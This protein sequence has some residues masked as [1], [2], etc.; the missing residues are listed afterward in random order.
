MPTKA[1]SRKN[2][3]SERE[4]QI[5]FFSN[6]RIEA[7]VELTHNTDGVYR[8]TLFEFKLTIPDINKVLFQSLKYL[9]HRR[10]KGDPVPTQILL[11]ALNEENAYL[12]NSED[13]LSYIEQT[14][15]G[16]ASKNNADFSTHIQPQKIDY[17]Q[18][19]GLRRITEI[20]EVEKYTKIHIDLFDVVGWSGRFYRENPTASKIKLFKELR[21]PKYFAAYIYP[22]TGDEK[23][24]KYIMDLLNDKQHKKELGA[25]YTPPAYCL[26]A[27]ELVRKAIRQI[28]A[29]H[30]YIILDRCA[31]TGNLE[32]FLTD[33]P[34]DDITI[35]ELSRYIDDTQKKKYLQDKADVITTFY[36]KRNFNEIT[37]GELEKHRTKLSL[38]DY[39]FDNELA[40]TIVN[41]YELKEWIVLNERIGDRVKLIIPPP[42]EV[43]NKAAL[44]DGGDALSVQFIKQGALGMTKEYD[45]SIAT[46]LSF[47]KNEKINLILYENPPYRDQVADNGKV[48]KSFLFAEMAK[49][50]KDLPNSNISTARDLSNQF[51]W[52]AWTYYLRKKDD[53]FILFSPVK[54]WKTLGLSNKKFI[55]GFLFNREFF[56]A[57]PSAISCILWQNI[58]ENRAELKL[59]AFDIDTQNT[60]QEDKLSYLKDVEIKKTYKTFEPFFDRRILDDDVLVQVY[61]ETDGTETTGR[62][63]DG[64]SRWNKNIIGYLRTDS[65]G[66]DPKH[67]SLTRQILFN[68]R[69]FYLRSDNFIDKLPLFAAKLYPQ[70][71]W[72]ERDIYFTTADGGDRYLHDKD[73]LKTCFVFTC[74]SQR[75]HCRSFDGSDGRFYKNELCFDK[76]TAASE[77][78]ASYR[79]TKEERDLVDTFG[80][81]LAKAKKTKNYN[82]KYAYGTYQIDGELNTRYKSEND[83]WIYD[84]PE[85]NTALNSLKTKLAK[86]YETT[87]QPKLFEYELLK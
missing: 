24:F 37:V 21:S 61:S 67:V 41:T 27:T 11:V 33:K 77:K 31:G 79:L 71:Q 23:D 50:L 15:A 49:I 16:A 54:Y 10:V 82:K 73:F 9:S 57:G 81:I 42:Q 35:G 53:C 47:V 32:E 3:L 19:A 51:I 87:I 56:H 44:V 7:D 64:K 36:N 25:F 14:Y 62:A 18:L 2:Y 40:H 22:W 8:G 78:I 46:L 74:L 52:S 83:E 69:G 65:F 5:D 75:N 68:A 17:G 70:K 38:H 1:K 85:L 20:L 55:A 76:G 43:D 26:K 45:E 80:D 60:P 34:V 39:I 63:V 13:F 48:S 6:L 72:Y 84:Y 12:F 66:V 58:N 86:Y 59:R 29:G 4:G 30:D 28:P